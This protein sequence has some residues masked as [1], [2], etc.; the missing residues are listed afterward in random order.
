MFLLYIACD[1]PGETTA[2]GCEGILV[3]FTTV[4]HPSIGS[5]L[6]NW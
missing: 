5:K 6:W 4:D 2:H 3:A 1:G